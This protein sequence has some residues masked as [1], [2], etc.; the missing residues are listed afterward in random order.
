MHR[1]FCEHCG[2]PVTSASEARP[3]LAIVRAGTLD[4]PGLARPSLTIWTESAPEWA[5]IDAAMPSVPG[6]PP[7]AG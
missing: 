5:C 2:T 3:H 4:D 7:P 1:G 6:Q